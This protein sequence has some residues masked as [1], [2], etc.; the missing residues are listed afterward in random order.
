M[1]NGPISVGALEARAAK[2]LLATDRRAWE[3]I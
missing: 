2:R 1:W 3:D